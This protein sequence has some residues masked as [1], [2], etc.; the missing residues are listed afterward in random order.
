[1]LSSKIAFYA[2]F[3]TLEK[4]LKKFDRK[5]YMDNCMSLE[6]FGHLKLKNKT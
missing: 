5:K 3:K 2:I 6:H 1:M 4:K